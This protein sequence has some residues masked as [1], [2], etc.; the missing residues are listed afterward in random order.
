MA[1]ARPGSGIE[2]EGLSPFD[3]DFAASLRSAAARG[4]RAK[5]ALRAKDLGQENILQPARAFTKSKSSARQSFDKLQQDR[6]REDALHALNGHGQ[7]LTNFKGKLRSTLV[8][9]N[10]KQRAALHKLRDV[11]GSNREVVIRIS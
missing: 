11:R 8:K 2:N 6:Q 10:S 1:K 9:S 4:S 3:E 5:D 7:W